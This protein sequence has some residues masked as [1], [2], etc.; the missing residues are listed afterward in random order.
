MV[1]RV[2]LDA[3]PEADWLTLTDLVKDL[4]GTFYAHRNL[5]CSRRQFAIW[6]LTDQQHFTLIRAHVDTRL[7][8]DLGIF[9]Q[10]GIDA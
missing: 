1:I 5:F 10:R 8:L 3:S 2:S 6:R 4:S 7:F 9:R